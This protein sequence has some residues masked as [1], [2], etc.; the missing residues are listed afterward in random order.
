MDHLRS[1]FQ[2]N[3]NLLVF[4]CC[5]FLL[6]YPFSAAA[7][8]M[9]PHPIRV[10]Y[11]DSPGFIEK[12][13][14]GTVDGYG[15]AY[16]NEI[17]HYTGWRYEYVYATWQE[18]L[19]LLAKGEL[20]ILG[21]AQ[22]TP[23][24]AASY[25]FASLPSGVEY[26]V[27]YVR[28]DDNEVYYNDYQSFNGLRIGVLKGNFQ[29]E[30]LSDV[31]RKNTFTYQPVLFDSSKAMVEALQNKQIDAVVTGSM[32]LYK[33][34]R[35]V[36]RFQPDPIYF[37]TT[38]GNKAVLQRLNDALMNIHANTPEF[39][40]TT[41]ATYYEQSSLLTQPLLTKKERDFLAHRGPITIG[42]LPNDEPLSAFSS[43]TNLPA[44]ILPGI[45]KELGRLSG[46]QVILK[47]LPAGARLDQSLQKEGFDLIAGIT[48]YEPYRNNISIRL[49]K[50]FFQGR[51]MAVANKNN[52]IDITKPQKVALPFNYIAYKNLI[53]NTYPHF[54]IINKANT[55]DCLMAVA[56][57][58]A[59]IALQNSH[60]ISY[61][62]QN[63]RFTDLKILSLFNFPD[64]LCLAAANN[65]DGNQLLTIFNKCID[66]LNP[67]TLD[68]IVMYE[69]VQSPYQPLLSDLAYKYNYLIAALLAVL[70]ILFTAWL[71][72]TLQRQ[73]YLELLE[74]KNLELETAAKQA[75]A[76]SEAK[77]SFLSRMSHEIRT[78]LNAI[79][80]FT[81][82]ALQ[83]EKQ[84]R[85]TEYLQKI[86]YSSELLLGIVNDVLDMSAIEN[87][88]LKLD[89][90]PFKLSQV[91][92][93]LQSLYSI[94]C[95]EKNISFIL[96]SEA[97]KHDI[98]LGDSLRL[99]QILSNLLS[100]AVK[101][102]AAGGQITL[103]ITQHQADSADQTVLT[104]VVTDTGCGMSEQMLAQVFQPFEQEDGSTARKYGGSGL[105]LS[106][107][108]YLVEL[109]GG[110]ISVN[111]AKG[112]GSTFTVRL[113][114]PYAEELAEK[115]STTAEQNLHGLHLLLAEDN[116]LNQELCLE[117]LKS[118]GISSDCAVNGKEALELFTN[119]APGT[120]ALILMD[121]QMPV[122]D[123]YQTTQAIR[124][125]T[126]PQAQT[127]PIISLS[128]DAFTED[129]RRAYA[130]GMNDHVSK[131]I[132]PEELFAAIT[133]VLKTLN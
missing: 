114:L 45:A 55:R 11:T 75:L 131:P 10:G 115:D 121:I 76:A 112:K 133:R 80:G 65:A 38:K 87:Q 124:S 118:R 26:M 105:G 29:T 86:S 119:S 113:T 117:L 128:A 41:Y 46:A 101:F 18:C 47:L 17:S 4:C 126:H 7:T 28:N 95:R 3:K 23:E 32:P 62:L 67:K 1:I 59:D 66:T 93:E 57:G 107:V 43:E 39:E 22:Y 60:I 85:S 91:L 36:A 21:M 109:M 77:S 94:Q 68:N 127:I 78:P 54:S 35:L 70:I 103:D 14:A 71:Y 72:F 132:V 74:A 16:L 111:S 15:V 82:L 50:P 129:I 69:T 120:Y 96:N 110:S 9:R 104:M 8:G 31:A 27:M 125:S 12:T 37:I 40:N 108:K 123:G 100:N 6:L 61:H 49:S 13:A 56:D 2:K 24:R 5:L 25:E 84:S 73:K 42:F 19:E 79:L 116:P 98:L 130:S 92:R 20:D 64:N 83:P 99:Q 48:D 30:I 34:L 102:T 97:F 44:G 51:V 63:P 53:L 33:D 52:F 122:L 106:I 81:R 89:N 90:S 58:E 88:K